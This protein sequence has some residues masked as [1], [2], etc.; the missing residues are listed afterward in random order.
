SLH[1]DRPSSKVDW[2]AGQVRLLTEP[3]DWPA[4]DRP[5][6]AAVSSFGISGTNVHTII[7]EAPVEDRPPTDTEPDAPAVLWPLS[8]RS[9]AALPAQAERLHAFLADRPELPPAAVA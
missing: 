7:E 8:A 1:V 9:A 4:G 3:R 5:R 2:D 6:R